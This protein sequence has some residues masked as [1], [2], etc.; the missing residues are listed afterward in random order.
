M[1]QAKAY[2]SEDFDTPQAE[3][4]ERTAESVKHV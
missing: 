3:V 4:V 1:H 2:P